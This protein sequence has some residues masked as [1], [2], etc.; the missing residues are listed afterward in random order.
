MPLP[1]SRSQVERSNTDR[2]AEFVQQHMASRQVPVLALCGIATVG[3]LTTV[4]AV[5]LGGTDKETLQFEIAKMGVQLIAVAGVGSVA[6]LAVQLFLESVRSASA[7]RQQSDQDEQRRIDRLRDERRRRDDL[8]RSTLELSVKTYNSVKCIRR[9]LRASTGFKWNPG[10]E[11]PVARSNWITAAPY[12][13]FVHELIDQQLQ[14]EELRR[15]SPLLGLRDVPSKYAAI[16]S[17]LGATIA[18]FEE[19]SVAVGGDPT[20]FDLQKLPRLY[21]LLSQQS[22][23]DE[24]SLRLKAITYALQTALLAPLDVSKG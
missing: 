16:E 1:T 11:V 2:N 12:S 3:L 9:R 13:L 6:T 10:S 15:L 19:M 22:F 18:E 7:A 20:G 23:Y 5:A 17:Y 14:F 21:D 4:I 24:V 8:L